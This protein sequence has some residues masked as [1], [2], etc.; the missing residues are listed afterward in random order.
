MLCNDNNQNSEKVIAEELSSLVYSYKSAPSQQVRFLILSLVPSKF[1]KIDCMEFFG[2]SKRMTEQARKI[3][4]EFGPGIIA[5]KEAFTRN[6]ID[7]SKVEHFID[8]LIQ[9]GYFQDVP[10][11]TTKLE[12]DSGE[13]FIVP[14]VVR[15]S[16]KL[17]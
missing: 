3:K 5:A 7:M 13:E 6:R 9:N 2:C 1:S 14:H 17:H 10:Y 15:T 8:F 4:S 12:L 16:I 11:G